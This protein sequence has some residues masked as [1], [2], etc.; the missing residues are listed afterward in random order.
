M[1]KKFRPP[2]NVEAYRDPLVAILHEVI[3]LP[4]L[5]HKQL[6]EVLKQH[7][8]DGRGVFSKNDLIQAYRKLAGSDGL[9][10]FDPEIVVRL[11]AKPIRTMSGVT[12]VTV[13]TKPFPCP[14]E[15]IFCPNDLRMPKSYLANEPGAQR[16]EQNRFDPYLQTY[17][18]LQTMYD[19]GHPT[20]KIEMIILGG[21][22]SFYP[23]TYQL[24]F[25]KR[26]FDALHDFGKG[27]SRV[28]EVEAALEDASQFHPERVTSALIDGT[29]FDQTYNQMVQQIYHAEMQRSRDHALAIGRGERS[30]SVVDEYATWGELA[31]AHR[32]NEAAACRCV[33]LVVETRPDHISA[34]E[35]IRIR[36]LG[37]TKV[38]IGIQCLDDEI[39]RKNKRGHT[40]E[41]TRRAIRLLRA[42][43][44]KIHA[45]WMP[46]LYGAT[47]QSDIE[48]YQRLFDDPTIRPDE[49]KLYPCSLIES[50]ELMQYYENGSWRPYTN[51]ELLDVLLTCF[52]HTPEYCRLTRVVRDIPS[53]DIVAGD[54]QTNFR[55]VVERELKQRGLP[56]PNIRAREIRGKTV[57]PDELHLDELWFESGI[58][59]EVFMQFVTD[60]RRIA[61]FLRLALP[62][63][64]PIL[65]E[66][67]DA[68]LIREVHVYGQALSLGDAQPGKAQHRGLG[69]QLIERAAEIA[70]ER[71]YARLAVISSVGTRAYYRKRGFVD[72]EL[73]QLRSLPDEGSAT[74]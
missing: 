43:G 40:V 38:Q 39:L 37:A 29:R 65:G 56:S 24:W 26:I 3:E 59:E 42:A 31:A 51:Q 53:T 8:K 71:G 44:F 25:I 54:M 61:G 47:P 14:G 50:A 34:D 69:T 28:A 67:R 45:H 58:G 46:N 20:D 4:N 5:T 30:R 9:P 72:G 49:L 13:L 74:G 55:Q 41:M 17:S 36:R 73:Y 11:R 22:W 21:T 32:K 15:C 57:A 18:R 60:D 23:E 68:A 19:L 12:P 33:G 1:G 27:I 62:T 66:L 70:A 16:A 64:D 35:V 2:I 52:Q 10:P 63:D 7:P 48:D 6:I